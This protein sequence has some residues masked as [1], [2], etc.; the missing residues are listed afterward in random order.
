[1]NGYINAQMNDYINAQANGDMMGESPYLMLTMLEAHCSVYHFN[2]LWTN[3]TA[4]PIQT[5]T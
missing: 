3:T 2:V 1:M 4:R 5:T